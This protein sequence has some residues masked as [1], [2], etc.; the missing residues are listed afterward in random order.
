MAVDDLIIRGGDTIEGAGAPGYPGDVSV[1]FAL[2]GCAP[3]EWRYVWRQYSA[4]LAEGVEF[5]ATEHSSQT[6]A[7]RDSTFRG[8][9]GLE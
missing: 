4:S 2:P 6:L 8:R 9:D 3:I 7:C 5:G 1:L